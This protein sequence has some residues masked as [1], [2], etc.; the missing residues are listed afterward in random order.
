MYTILCYGDSHVWG[1]MP[2]V[3]DTKTMLAGRF[4]KQQRWTTI[5]QDILGEQY[6]VVT[7]CLNGR[8]TLVDEMTPG[9]PFRNGLTLLPRSLEMHYP[10]DVVV[11]MLGTNDLKL[12][13]NQSAQAIT[14]NMKQLINVIKVSQRGPDASVPKI[15]LMAPP[16]IIKIKNLHPQFDD[17]AVIAKSYKL[18]KLYRALAVEEGCAFLDTAT[19]VRASELDGFHMDAQQLVLL[20]HAVARVVKQA[21]SVVPVLSHSVGVV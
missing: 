18:G 17:D 6:D 9:R 3:F 19:V 7:D 4:E 20:G 8:T 21:L 5:M 16:P 12:Q 10:V 2:G 11:L 14:A 1:A 13:Y 15:L